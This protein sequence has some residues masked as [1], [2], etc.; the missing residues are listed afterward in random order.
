MVEFPL[1]NNQI[2]DWCLIPNNIPIKWMGMD[3]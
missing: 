1:E 3:G 2:D